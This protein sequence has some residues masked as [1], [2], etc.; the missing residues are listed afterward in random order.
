MRGQHALGDGTDGPDDDPGVREDREPPAVVLR[1]I[2]NDDEW[3][4]PI[5][6]QA[7]SVRCVVLTAMVVFTICRPFSSFGGQTVIDVRE[8][9]HSVIRPSMVETVR[10]H[11]GLRHLKKTSLASNGRLFGGSVATQ[12]SAAS[13]S[14]LFSAE[15]QLGIP[16]QVVE[17]NQ[18]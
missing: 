17:R 11:W 10:V 3:E 14:L 18:A 13:P 12:R 8:V 2:A 6:A 4:A 16:C 7:R 5:W 15:S 1:Y 9:G